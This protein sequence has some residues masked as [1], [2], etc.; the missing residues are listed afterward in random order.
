MTSTIADFFAF[1]LGVSV[2]YILAAQ[3]MTLAGRTGVFLV[4]NE[5]VMQA[6]ASAGFLAAY[7]NNGNLLIGFAAG[8]I[9]GGLFGVLMSFLSVSLK[10][11]QFV[12]GLSLLILAEGAGNFMYKAAIGETF[13]PP[14]VPT[15]HGFQIP[16][17]S[18]IPYIGQILFQQNP[19]FYA[20]IFA[21]ILI[22]Y[23]LYRTPYGLNVRAIGENPR[24]ADTQGL[25]VHLTRYVYTFLGSALIGIAGAYI[26]FFLTGSYTES[27][28]SGR[29]WISIAVTLL[30]G[31]KPLNVVASGLVFAGFEVFSVYGQLLGLPVSSDFLL[32]VPFIATL[33][34]LI[35]VYR[36]AEL[37][38][39]LGRN[40]DRESKID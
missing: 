20:S 23:V 4:Y 11:N 27:L 26:P 36:N 29:G 7:L 25:N 2:I 10:Q 24:V 40:Y 8:A 12:V 18:S 5:G 16:Y 30:G 32:M 31:W 35:Q 13:S 14:S 3:G 21:S 39:G 19:V 37:P 1:A 34:I 28:V 15:L 9:A 6:S 17:V 38:Q 33:L 22:W